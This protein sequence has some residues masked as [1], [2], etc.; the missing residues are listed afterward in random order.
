MNARHAMSV[1]QPSAPGPYGVQIDLFRHCMTFPSP[2][3][4]E[5]SIPAALILLETIKEVYAS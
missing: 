5:P 3:I 1:Q 2:G 4:I